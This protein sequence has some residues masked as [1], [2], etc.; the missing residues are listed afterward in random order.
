[1]K[2]VMTMTVLGMSLLALAVSA[3][4]PT[5]PAPETPA[6]PTDLPAEVETAVKEALSAQAGVPV[7]DIEVVAAQQQEWPDACLGLGEEGE[8]CAQVITPGWRVVVV[9]DGE[10]VI[11]RTDEQGD[12]IRM[13]E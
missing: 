2:H 3:C 9:A 1:M 6:P 10:E 12:V 7:E 5:T 4:A 11:F 13:E 8:A